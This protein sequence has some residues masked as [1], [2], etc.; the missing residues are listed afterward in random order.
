MEIQKA[1]VLKYSISVLSFI[2]ILISVYLL[3]IHFSG[4]IAACPDVGIIN[5]QNVLTSPYSSFFYIPL[6]VFGIIYF[7]LIFIL[8]FIDKLKNV[9]LA[10]SAIS[11]IV[12]FSLL[13]IEF[14]LIHS[15]CLWCSSIHL[16]ALLIFFISLYRYIFNL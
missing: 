8:S 4:G 5:C 1:S 2:A 12:V 9:I 10:L 16:I 3:Y 13:Y 6:P 11:I 7:L 15:I 14:G